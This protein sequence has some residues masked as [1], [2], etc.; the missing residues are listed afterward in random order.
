MHPS[1]SRVNAEKTRCGPFAHPGSTP[2]L[3]GQCVADTRDPGEELKDTN[4][5]RID[6]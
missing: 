3:H 2:I 5:L 6:T 1:L 4:I